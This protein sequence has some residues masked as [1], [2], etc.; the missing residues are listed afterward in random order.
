MEDVIGSVIKDLREK[1]GISIEELA[2]DLCQPERML[3]IERGTGNI[4]IK[5]LHLIANK[6]SVEVTFL[7]NAGNTPQFN[8]IEGIQTLIRKYIRQRNYEVVAEIVSN[9]IHQSKKISLDFCQ[10][11]KWHEGICVWHL[12]RDKEKAISLLESALEITVTNGLILREREVEI[13]NSIGLIHLDAQDKYAAILIFKKAIH[14]LENIPLLKG[15][16]I[17]IRL[18]HALAQT[19]TKI[20]NFE[21]SLEQTERAIAICISNES[22]YLLGELHYSAGENLLELGEKEKGMDYIQKSK[23][24]FEMKKKKKFVHL[25]NL[26]VKR[27]LSLT[28]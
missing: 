16:N 11:L 13:L 9:E 25:V 24:I 5:E 10:F 22:L 28:N 6:L 26:E 3:E 8:Y 2:S 27:I 23:F 19:L 18:L 1:K 17:Y 15:E 7:L 14:H 4:T 20:G 12:E 21:E